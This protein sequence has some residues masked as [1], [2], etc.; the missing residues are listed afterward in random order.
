MNRWQ[1]P[2]KSVKPKPC[3]IVS[4][5]GGDA[6]RSCRTTELPVAAAALGLCWRP[7]KADRTIFI[8]TTESRGSNLHPGMEQ[9]LS[10]EKGMEHA[11]GVPEAQHASLPSTRAGRCCRNRGR[12][13]Q[14]PRYRCLLLAP[15]S[16][17]PRFFRKS[18]AG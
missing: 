15:P 14:V 13:W 10:Q 2:V 17:Q 6:L 7:P 8:V 9:G 5:T 16:L 18:N 1:S 12:C 11:P 4:L 3:K